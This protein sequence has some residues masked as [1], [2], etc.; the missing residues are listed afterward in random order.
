M[1]T[2]TL[3]GRENKLE[4]FLEKQL[5]FTHTNPT[6]QLKRVDTD[7][8]TQYR[9]TCSVCADTNGRMLLAHSRERNGRSEMPFPHPRNYLLPTYKGNLLISG[10][11]LNF[12]N[13]FFIS[14]GNSSPISCQ[15]PRREASLTSL[16]MKTQV[17]GSPDFVFA[18]LEKAPAQLEG[19]GSVYLG[20][21][22]I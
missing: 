11:L 5:R 10:L 12:S 4:Q 18:S 13:T 2:A 1:T 6:S 20:A 9:Q 16:H 19:N 3:L 7:L 15:H 22:I 14:A 17:R 8:L 21:P